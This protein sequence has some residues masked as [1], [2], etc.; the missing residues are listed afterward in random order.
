MQLERYLDELRRNNMSPHTIHS[1]GSDLRDFLNYFSPAGEPPPGIAEIDLLKLR[2]YMAHLH[3]RELA[4]ASI[5]RKIAALRMLF[6]FLVR[7]GVA[8]INVARL[9][10]LPKAGRKLPGPSGACAARQKSE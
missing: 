10:R 8:K 5:R 3:D 1:Y 2:E 7:E 6:K 9:L 4:A